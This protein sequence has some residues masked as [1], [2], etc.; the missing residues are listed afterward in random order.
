MKKAQIEDIV[1]EVI[2]RLEASRKQEILVITPDIEHVA[3]KVTAIEK[4]WHVTLF[5]GDIP[6]TTKQAI[7][8]EVNQDI[9][10]KGALGITD[11]EETKLFSKLMHLEFQVTLVPTDYLS[12]ILF[13]ERRNPY[14]QQLI[15]YKE[16]LKNYG[17]EICPFGDF[18]TSYK[19]P[20]LFHGKVITVKD[21]ETWNKGR[22]YVRHGTIITP[23]AMDV[24]KEKGII[25][26]KL[27]PKKGNR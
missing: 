11:T 15:T 16:Q 13:T 21:I 22:I 19:E 25:I 26:E 20:Q 17:V 24:A 2:R 18:V 14:Q 3:D 8:L 6:T 7:F 23:L 9:L 5:Q 27:M 12:N 10:V 1:T 4:H